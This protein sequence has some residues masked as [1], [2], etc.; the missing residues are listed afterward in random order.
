MLK[1]RKSF[2]FYTLSVPAGERHY[3][4]D[5]IRFLVQHFVKYLLMRQG[6]DIKPKLLPLE[7]CW[8]EAVRFFSKTVACAQFS[9]RNVCVGVVSCSVAFP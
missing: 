6:P 2:S 9:C 5:L 3:W 7:Q 8:L 1:Y 4:L